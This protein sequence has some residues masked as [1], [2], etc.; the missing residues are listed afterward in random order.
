VDAICFFQPP[1]FF[2]LTVEWSAS[3]SH[4]QIAW[5]AMFWKWVYSMHATYFLWGGSAF[6]LPPANMAIAV[7]SM[8]INRV[9]QP[10][11]LFQFP[12]GFGGFP[13]SVLIAVVS[14]CTS[15]CWPGMGSGSC[16][17]GNG[18]VIFYA[19]GP[20]HIHISRCWLHQNN[21]TPKKCANWVYTIFLFFNF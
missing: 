5:P 8:W 9:T 16:A 14:G 15:H 17:C 12:C 11:Y 7:R 13:C 19:G 4:L 10:G 18:N 3:T 21:H 1:P 2:L 6:C 20:L